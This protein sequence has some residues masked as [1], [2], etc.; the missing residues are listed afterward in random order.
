MEPFFSRVKLNRDR[1]ESFEAHPFDLAAVRLIETLKFDRPVTYLVGEN[2][3]GKSTVVEALAV[4]AGFNAE[5]GSKNFN[6][7][8]TQTH[9]ALHE[10]LTLVRAGRREKNGF[11]L[12]AES[13]Y[14]VASEIIN[15]GVGHNYGPRGLHD[16]S[17]GES[18][19]ALVENRFWPD[20]LY[21]LDEP[22]SAL[23]PARQLRLLQE[24]D[25]LVGQRCQFIIATHSPILMSYPTSRLYW[26]SRDGVEEKDWKDTEHYTLTKSFLD[27]P[28]AF[29][30]HLG[31]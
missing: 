10:S 27:R 3:A 23:S 20:S 28:S 15:L 25:R 1:V 6:F 16:Q 31:T 22:E 21:F 8:T 12:R 9:S 26:L 7:D 14:N 11:F 13:F 17:H 2:G 30:R 24:I 29:L 4:T 5:G 18:F 19:M